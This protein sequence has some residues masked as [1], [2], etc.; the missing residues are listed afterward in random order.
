[1]TQPRTVQSAPGSADD[2]TVGHVQVGWTGAT[3]G[4]WHLGLVQ[5]VGPNGTVMGKTL[6]EVD[7]R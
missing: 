6:V 1:M 4:K 5:H 7:N 2:A 3:S